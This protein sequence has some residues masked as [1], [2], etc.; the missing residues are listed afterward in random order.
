[1]LACLITWLPN[2]ELEVQEQEI[3]LHMEIVAM[4]SIMNCVADLQLLLYNGDHRDRGV[5]PLMLLLQ[6]VSM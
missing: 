5:W 6:N 3:D 1:M 2:Y 4:S